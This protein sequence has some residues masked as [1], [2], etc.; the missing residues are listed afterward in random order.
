MKLAYL[1]GIYPLPSETFVR[2]EIESLEEMGQPVA[3]FSARGWDS[4]LVDPKD[5]A[6]QGR[7]DYLLTGGKGRLF[8]DALATLVRHPLRSL[9]MLPKVW[10]LYRNARRKASVFVAYALQ[11][12]AFRTRTA[13]QGITHVHCHFSNNATAIAMLAHGLGGPRYSFTVHGPDELVDPTAR[14]LGMKARGAAFVVAITAYC[15]GRI[16]DEAPDVANKVRIIPCGIDPQDFAFDGAAPDTSRIV[17]VGRLCFNKGQRHIPAAVAQV[18]DAFPDLVIDLLGGGDDEALIRSEIAKHGV[19]R[20][21]ILHGWATGAQVRD[22]L[23]QSRALLLPS[24]AEGLPIVIMEALAVGRPVL[25]TRITGIPEL[26]DSGCGWLFEPGDV[27]AIAEALRGV[28]RATAAERAAMGAEGRR[29]VEERHDLRK[30]A[31]L[32]LDEFKEAARELKLD[33]QEQRFDEGVKT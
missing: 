18:K 6:E 2:K 17:C 16:L 3:R 26:V 5:I 28:M 11:A 30:S 8:A 32:L 24:Y 1:L 7:T 23:R 21:V 12:L 13:R 4:Q 10:R 25:T 20:Q 14:S 9:A 29:R 22:A 27:D 33:G 31:A 15:R 19:E